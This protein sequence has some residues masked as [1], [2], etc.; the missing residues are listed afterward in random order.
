MNATTAPHRPFAH[1]PGVTY[2]HPSIGKAARPPDRKSARATLDEKKRIA[3][4]G[5][6]GM[7]P[8]AI[9]LL[10]GRDLATVKKHM[11]ANPNLLP[12]A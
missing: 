8:Y 5:S 11:P 6:E 3:I 10:I 9:S 4:L 1:V 2:P 12:H 7:T